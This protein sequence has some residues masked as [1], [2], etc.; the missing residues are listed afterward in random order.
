[1]AEY[2]LIADKSGNLRLNREEKLERYRETI[3]HIRAVIEPEED[4]LACMASMACLLHNALPYFFWTGFYRRV[5]PRMLRVGPYQGTLGCIDIPFER[6]VCGACA[7][8][9]R[10][11]VVDDVSRFPGHIACDAN[12]ASEIV[13]PVRDASGTL[14]AVLD[15]DSTITGAFDET[16]QEQLEQC[17]ALLRDKTALPLVRPA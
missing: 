5:G 11:I 9:E 2:T 7:S 13:V 12:S 1:M 16:D 14:I 8:E 4:L 10:T 3:S 17:V 6:G 15:V